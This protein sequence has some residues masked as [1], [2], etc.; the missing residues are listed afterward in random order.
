MVWLYL[1]IYVSFQILQR[2]VE[3]GKFES[4]PLLDQLGPAMLLSDTLTFLGKTCALYS[5]VFYDA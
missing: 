1:R 4:S 2:Y 3:D 5:A